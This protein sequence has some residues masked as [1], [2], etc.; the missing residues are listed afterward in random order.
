M[1]I[2]VIEHIFPLRFVQSLSGTAIWLQHFGVML[3]PEIPSM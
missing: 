3:I 2:G 1:A